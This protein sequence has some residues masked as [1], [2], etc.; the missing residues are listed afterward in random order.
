MQ[1]LGMN[2]LIST[3]PV[4]FCIMQIGG[5][6]FWYKHDARHLQD[7]ESL[8]L[9]VQVALKFVSKITGTRVAH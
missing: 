3:D 2:M 5:F 9:N 8:F 6:L 4:F 7:A 1:L